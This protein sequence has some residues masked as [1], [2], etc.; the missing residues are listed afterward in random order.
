MTSSSSLSRAVNSLAVATVLL[1]VTQVLGLLTII[2]AEIQITGFGVGLVL[3][4]ASLFWLLRVRRVIEI[5]AC[6]LQEFAAGNFERRLVCIG[7]GGILDDLVGNAND[8][9]DQID[10][11]VR[12]ATASLEHVTA[13]KYYRRIVETGMHGALLQG[14]RTVNDATT[15]MADKVARFGRVTHDFDVSSGRLVSE[16]AAATS[17]FRKTAETMDKSAA[18]AVVKTDSVA[19]SVQKTG[20]S[21][22]HV[23]TLIEGLNDCI[24]S[25]TEQFSRATKLAQAT[26]GET[27]RVGAMVDDLN[28]AG[29]AIGEVLTLIASIAKKTNLLALNAT[30]EAARAGAAGKGFAVVAQEVKSLAR[31]T[32]D[33]TVGIGNHIGTIQKATGG[34]T[35]AFQSASTMVREIHHLV[36]TVSTA[37][38]QQYTAVVDIAKVMDRVSSDTVNVVSDICDVTRVADTTGRA[39]VVMLKA[40]EQMAERTVHLETEVNQFLGEVKRVL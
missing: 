24:A 7:E 37:V 19:G 20:L 3:L 4:A 32:A 36:S 11:F 28:T 9:F 5:T 6:A 15:G 34:V 35:S 25:L 21:I 22:E 29:A 16:F 40:A 27:D 33:A 13:G 2:S 23:A 18:L 38:D 31:Q 12:E 30:M 8:V 39:A 26:A 17:E 1:A 14:A 10:A